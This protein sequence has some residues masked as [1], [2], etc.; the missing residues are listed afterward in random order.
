[1]LTRAQDL[2]PC[3]TAAHAR[4]CRR[5]LASQRTRS[6]RA[7]ATNRHKPTRIAKNEQVCLL[8]PCAW[9][10]CV[11]LADARCSWSRARHPDRAARSRRRT[12]PASNKATW[13]AEC[14]TSLVC[15]HVRGTHR[16]S[17]AHALRLGGGDER[18]GHGV[19]CWRDD[20]SQKKKRQLLPLSGCS[21]DFGAC[22]HRRSA[23]CCHPLSRPVESRVGWSSRLPHQYRPHALKSTCKKHAYVAEHCTL[24][25]VGSDTSQRGCSA[26][27]GQTETRFHG[28][29][30]ALP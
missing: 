22:L 27:T 12:L 19:G 14:S 2:A 1:M 11:R 3:A 29:A 15:A 8:R 21:V 17:L 26:Q 20:E 28:Q 7:R 13:Y 25:C 6:A 24:A 9:T 23:A 10:L 16:D 4:G 5:P 30:L 18:G